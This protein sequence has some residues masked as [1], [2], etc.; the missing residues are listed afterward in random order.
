MAGEE[1]REALFAQSSSIRGTRVA[2]EESQCDRRVEST[3]D[4]GGARPECGEFGLEAIGQRDLG[5]HEVL[6]SAG[7]RPQGLRLIRV[8]HQHSET[9]VVGAGKLGRREGVERVGLSAGGTEARPGGLQLVG[10]DGE[11]HEA[12]FQQTLDQIT[13]R[14]FDGDAFDLKLDKQLTHPTEVSLVVGEAPLQERLAIL[15]STHTWCVSLAQSSPAHLST[16][17]LLRSPTRVAGSPTGSYH[18]GCS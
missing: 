6:A 12:C 8:G 9:K 5:F 13:I 18:C 7:E 15:P 2:L 11:H 17:I 14:T 3:E 1:A 10:M 16:E 4:H